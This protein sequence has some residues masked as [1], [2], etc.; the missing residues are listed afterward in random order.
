M[1]YIVFENLK[2]MEDEILEYLNAN[3]GSYKFIELNMFLMEKYNDEMCEE[4]RKALV[5]LE[6]SGKISVKENRHL[7][8]CSMV[9]LKPTDKSNTI[10]TLNNY[11]IYAKLE[12]PGRKFI[13][14][15]GLMWYQTEIA[16][17]QFDDYPKIKS[18]SK[19]TFWIAIITA[20]VVIIELILKL[21]DKL[22]N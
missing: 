20:G 16:K 21:V 18:K 7:H 22:S 15:Q 14:E 12:E 1:V 2:N 8:M 10:T 3:N 17:R 11:D 6:T 4:I 5:T 19:W 13:K 9:K